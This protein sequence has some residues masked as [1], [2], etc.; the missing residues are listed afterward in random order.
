MEKKPEPATV[1]EGEE[2]YDHYKPA[3]KVGGIGPH[4]EGRGR[5][6][7]KTRREEGRGTGRDRSGPVRS[8][9][10]E[11]RQAEEVWPWPRGRLPDPP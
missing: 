1:Q 7:R 4:W 8:N 9:P 2:G 10:F 3:G 6:E 11:G 5:C